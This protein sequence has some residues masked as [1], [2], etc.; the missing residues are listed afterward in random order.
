MQKE[1][2]NAETPFLRLPAELRDRVYDLAMPKGVWLG[3]LYHTFPRR[4]ALLQVCQAIRRGVMPILY[5]NSTIVFDFG[6]DD[7]ITL[8]S[9]WLNDQSP[10][11]I[12]SMRHV[13]VS[14]LTDCSCGVEGSY[15]GRSMLRISINR[16]DKHAPFKVL[17]DG[18]QP[19]GRSCRVFEGF[20]RQ[21]TQHL[22]G[23]DLG[24]EDSSLSGRSLVES[25]EIVEAF[26][27]RKV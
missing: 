24:A 8:A 7:R 22:Q 5:G 21:A 9:T 1:R 23:L 18:Q 11:A 25:L 10:E 19:H 27:I 15:W 2:E 12:A 14:S 16:D 4:F 20:V 17:V 13:H 26:S 6:F 3:P